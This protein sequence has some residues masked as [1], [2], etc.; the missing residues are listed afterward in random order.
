MTPIE[1]VAAEAGFPAE[2]VEPWGRHKAK[3]TV[4]EDVLSRPPHGRYV[5]VAGM[6]PTPLGEGKT[7]TTIGLAMALQKLGEK[8]VATL[9]QPSMG[10][11][12]GIKGGGTGGGRACLVPDVEINLHLTGDFHAVA[13]ANNLLA[14]HLDTQLLLGNPQDIVPASVTWRRVV[15]V[16]DRALRSIVVGLGGARNGIPRE[17]GFD[18]VP[19]SEVMAVLGLSSGL[20]DLRERLGRIIVGSRRDGEP[21]TVEDLR[22]GGAMTALLRDAVRPNLVATSEGSAAVVHT[23]PFADIAHGNSSILGDRLALAHADYVL[24]EA[25]FGADMGAEKF[26]N[27]KCR[28]SGL[29]PDAAVLVVTVRAI[30]MHGG[31]LAISSRGR[32]S[33]FDQPDPDLVRIGCA[34]VQAH[35][36]I[37]R[38]HGV[39][40]VVAINRMLGDD[41]TD[42]R[43][44]EESVRASGAFA[45]AVSDAYQ[46]GGDGCVAL[47]ETVREATSAKSEFGFLYED[48]LALEKK[49]ETIATEV[50]GAQRI[51]LL[52]GVTKG[53]RRF[54]SWGFGALPVCIAKTPLSLSDDPSRKNRPRGFTFPVSEIR[55][56]AGAG[57]ICALS[58]TRSTMPG[59]SATPRLVGIDVDVDG[60]VVGL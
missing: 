19:A 8:A 36:A 6:T 4:P 44:V 17:T 55:A 54:E 57:F 26:F 37:L 47:A 38:R 46:K 49:I 33:R 29:R 1:T 21:V 30:K 53:L 24:T 10:P 60:N 43:A 41:P 35:I 9:R 34:N 39:P 40:V 28:T 52:P 15:D 59:L 13:A 48:A 14:A 7:T 32:D 12:F 3:L 42:I 58:G 5:L 45:V 22:C 20:A 56:Y 51:R 16:N 27:I 11:V 31:D 2:I 25:G 18:I 50:Y 23:G